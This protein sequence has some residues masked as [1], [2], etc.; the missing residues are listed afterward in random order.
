MATVPTDSD[1]SSS[2]SAAISTLNVD[3]CNAN[4]DSKTF[5]AIGKIL[6][7]AEIEGEEG[8]VSFIRVVFSSYGNLRLNLYLYKNED[9][10][11]S[12]FG[13]CATV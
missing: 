5:G 2:L 7:S 4:Y 13:Y 8:E 1:D 11:S 12:V 3:Q 6:A 10:Q 9:F